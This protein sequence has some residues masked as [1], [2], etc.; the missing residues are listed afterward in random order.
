MTLVLVPVPLDHLEGTAHL[1]R[2]YILSIAERS[3]NDPEAMTAML[4]RGEA[5]AFLVWEPELQKTFAFL[6]VQYVARGVDRVGQLIWLMGENRA[7]WAHLFGELETYLRDHEG[8]KAIK[9][10]TRPG[11]SK[12]LKSNGYRETHV[13]ME[14]EMP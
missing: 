6:G 13:V 7:A 14:K 10:I 5:Q 2:P 12:H 11:W 3:K 1:W 9:A 4:Y 8:C